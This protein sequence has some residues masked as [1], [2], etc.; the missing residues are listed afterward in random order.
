MLATRFL[1][2]VPVTHFGGAPG[3]FVAP[4]GRVP[5][6]FRYLASREDGEAHK[7]RIFGLLARQGR[8]EVPGEWDFHHLVDPVH[9]AEIDFGGAFA[10][11]HADELPCVLLHDPERRTVQRLVLRAAPDAPLPEVARP[12]VLARAVAQRAR[13]VM[14]EHADPRRHSVLRARVRE[15]ATRHR[16]AY[17]G[18]P[19][20][21]RVAQNVFDDALV[22]LR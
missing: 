2:G 19:V 12:Q 18:D 9:L 3:V 5:G 20:L 11:H 8:P 17:A 10:A 7:A 14:S 22:L 6:S 4:H 16:D 13:Q 21:Q 1:R 15:M